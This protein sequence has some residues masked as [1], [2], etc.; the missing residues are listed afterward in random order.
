MKGFYKDAMFPA[1]WV[2]ATVLLS[3]GND[4]HA[5]VN[6]SGCNSE[7]STTCASTNQQVGN[8]TPTATASNSTSISTQAGNSANANGAQVNPT[9]TNNPQTNQSI[10][11][12]SQSNQG[13]NTSSS[14]TNQAGITTS[15]GGN[16][17][18]GGNNLSTGSSS[19][20]GNNT[21]GNN[22]STGSS[23]SGGNTTSSQG[24]AGGNGGSGG[25]GGSVAGSGNSSNLNSA[26]GGAGG[27]SASTATGGAQGQGQGQQQANN[28]TNAQGQTSSN[29]NKG[30]NT[31]G[32]NTGTNTSANKVN[33]SNSTGASTSK[34]GKSASSSAGGTASNG[35]TGSGNNTTLQEGA[36]NT[37]VDGRTFVEAAMVP[38]T[39]SSSVGIGQVMV[40]TTACG[41]RRAVKEERVVGTFH[42]LFFKDYD[43]Q[44]VTDKL[45]DPMDANGNR[46][47]RY[48]KE[49]D[50]DGTE[51]VYG[52][53]FVISQTVVAVAGAR[54][55]AM[56]GGAGIG[57]NGQ[58]GGGSSASMSQLVTTIE[59]LECEVPHA[60]RSVAIVAP[61]AVPH[62][63][64]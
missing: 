38:P 2:L 15:Q 53:Q 50:S 16:S 55:I 6:Q 61:V 46:L 23:S 41:P 33:S 3:F 4:A 34:G 44:G 19:S 5:Q 64:Q 7:S 25:A 12:T 40:T 58:L 27:K 42:G 21:G 31:S 57:P 35:A 29:T 37:N 17:S 20:G 8:V 36:T 26:S 45:I 13:G 49:V 48:E 9:I 39:P 32:T 43:D 22:L 59:V 28:G 63:N 62:I 60:Q 30:G 24:G 56:G 10:G 1:V 18:S 51:H 11:A 52:N 54:N 14:N 47:P